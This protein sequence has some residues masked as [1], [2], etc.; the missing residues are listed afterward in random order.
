MN[1]NI[2]Q[3]TLIIDDYYKAIDYYQS[4]LGFELIE[5]KY[6]G[7]NKRWVRI[8]PPGS[9]GFSLLLA[10]S[11]TEEQKKAIGNQSGGRIFL[12]LNTDNAIRNFELYQSKQ[13]TVIREPSNEPYGTVFVFQEMYGNLWD[14]IEPHS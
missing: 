5:D 9:K 6:I 11:N 4:T 1:Q 8:T 7:N 2:F 12:F 14:V 3:I 13:V 10:K